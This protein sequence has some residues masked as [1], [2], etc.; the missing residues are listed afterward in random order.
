MTTRV[1]LG[2]TRRR[3]A[4]AVMVAVCMVVLLGFAALAIDVGALYNARGDLQRSADA[5]ALAAAAMLSE[6]ELAD[7]VAAA[8]ETA[9]EVV[10]MNP[11]LGKTVRAADED[12]DFLRSRLSSG[13][14]SFSATE[15]FPD[16][17]RVSVRLDETSPNG[18][19]NLFFAAIFGKHT[20]SVTASAT[21]GMIPRDIALVADLSASHT[22]DSEFRNYRTT[23]INMHDVWAA[24]PGGYG[25]IDSTWGP[26]DGLPHNDV[27]QAAGP[28]WGFMKKLGFGNLDVGPGYNPTTDDGLIHLPFRQDWNNSLLSD[29]LTEQHYSPDE[30]TAI[31]RSGGSDSSTTY[32]ARVAVG[33]GL[34][35]WNS[36]MAGGRWEKLGLAKGD[37][38]TAL[39]ASEMEWGETLMGRT[40]AESAAIWRAYITDYMMTTNNMMYQANSAFRYRYGVKTFINYLLE[41]RTEPS[42]T[43]ELANVPAQ[44]MQAVKDAVAQMMETLAALESPD[45][46]SLEV[47]GTVGVHE[48]D[49]TS[50]FEAVSNRLREMQAAHH[51]HYTNIGGG[52]QRAI[53]E[54]SGPRARKFSRKVII[55]YTD[56]VA[57]INRNLNYDLSGAKQYAW[58]MAGEA[59]R[60]GYRIYAVSVGS[61]ADKAFMDR[62]AE[63][64]NGEHFHAEGTIAQYSAQLEKILNILS[65]QRA[66]QLIE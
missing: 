60:R 64:G 44:P 16:A 40:A 1:A 66:V 51:G 5:A 34:A 30:I 37:G 56:G 53:E 27:R 3:G 4:V 23:R 54:L 39:T 17:V 13:R 58:E 8:R 32:P 55:L 42:Q 11:V 18:P 43:H 26:N 65:S 19:L 36:G 28:A 61:E 21:A 47:Y 24:L 7:P 6:Y 15:L 59:A 31:M 62:I 25:D 10:Q 45:R 46:I 22:D 20:T 52:L 63:L 49:L 9:K 48:V 38:N 14:Y 2:C 33:L 12:V 50:D 57:N 41:E 35:T 29:Y